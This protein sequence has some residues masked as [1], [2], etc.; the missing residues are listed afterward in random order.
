MRSMPLVHGFTL[1]LATGIFLA[2]VLKINSPHAASH[3]FDGVVG[4]VLAGIEEGS[5]VA[6]RRYL[7]LRVHQLSLL[8]RL[9]MLAFLLQT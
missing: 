4:R 6:S 1:G 7:G 3:T 2:T 9:Q 5:W 8:V